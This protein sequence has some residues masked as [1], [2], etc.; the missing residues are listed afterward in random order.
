MLLCQALMA[1][2]LASLGYV[3]KLLAVAGKSDDDVVHVSTI[4]ICN[5]LAL[6]FCKLLFF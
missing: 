5:K 2:Y 6:P 3:G 4:S 1:P